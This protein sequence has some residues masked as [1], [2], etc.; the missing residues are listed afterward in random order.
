MIR[1][2]VGEEFLFGVGICYRLLR[3]PYGA[4]SDEVPYA[5]NCPRIMEEVL[6]EELGP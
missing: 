2:Q 5:M 1:I 4:S 6:S 3:S